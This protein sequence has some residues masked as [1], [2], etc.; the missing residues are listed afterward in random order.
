MFAKLFDHEKYGQL[1]VK[2]DTDNEGDPE[3]RTY[4]KPK[5]LGVCSVAAGFKDDDEGW[6]LAEKNL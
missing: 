1:L 4:F 3:V 6:E 5:G 2:L